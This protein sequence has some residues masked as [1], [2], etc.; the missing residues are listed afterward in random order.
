MG[1][2]G[3]ETSNSII[4]L[5]LSYTENGYEVFRPEFRMK[6]GFNICNCDEDNIMAFGKQPIH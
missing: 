3:M 4:R 1:K 2:A 5:P 6:V